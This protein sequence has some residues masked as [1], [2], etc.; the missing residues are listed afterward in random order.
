[1]AA[2]LGGLLLIVTASAGGAPSRL[3]TVAATE[4]CLKSLPNAIG[5]L[6]PATPPSPPAP[7]VYRF[8]PG[9]F[10]LPVEGQVGAWYGR[11]K[12]DYAG[13]ILSFFKSIPTAQTYFKSL[14]AGARVRNVL[15]NWGYAS[16]SRGWQDTV[17]SCLRPATPG[18]TP[19]PTG[20]TPRARIATF[21]G[22]WG[23]H[24]R[25]LWITSG[26]RGLE[27]TDD[28]CCHHVYRMSFQVIS[29]S[30]TLTRA[31]AAYRA[32]SF[33]R[34]D[35]SFRSRLHA[36]RIGKPLLRNGIVTNTQT[37]VFFCSDPAWWAT[38]VCGA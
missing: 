6:P 13:V 37:R 20:S 28:G 2:A 27:I 1:M 38:G 32:T 9:R 29:V 26:G 4:T 31:T 3:Y 24:T 8:P 17:R 5:G 10:Q 21:A 14:G 35:S 12:G 11:G 36:G 16:V 33:N 30:G 19:T 23:G 18:R 34:Y 22:S 7:F 25:R 15:L